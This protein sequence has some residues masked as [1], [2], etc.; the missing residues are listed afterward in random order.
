MKQSNNGNSFISNFFNLGVI[1][2]VLTI[3]KMFFM[4]YFSFPLSRTTKQLAILLLLFTN[5]FVFG[6]KNIYKAQVVTMYYDNINNHDDG[7]LLDPQITMPNQI[8]INPKSYVRLKIDNE[9]GPFVWVKASI[10]VTMIPYLADGTPNTENAIT[11]TLTAEY[12]PY[13]N[14]ANFSD[15]SVYELSNSY[16]VNVKIEGVEFTNLTTGFASNEVTQNVSIELGFESERYYSITNQLPVITANIESD[17]DGMPLALNFNWSNLTGALQYELQ[18]TWVDNYE[19]DGSIK[20]PELIN[21][22]SRDFELNNTKIRTNATTYQIPL[23]YSRGYIIFRV[24]GV[25]RFVDDANTVD[26]EYFG[27]WSSGPENKTTVATWQNSH[28]RFSGHEDKKNW[29]FQ[30][31]YAEQGKKKEVVSYFDGS[32]R[33]RQTVTK[34]NTDKNNIVVGE[35][36]YDTQGRAAVEVLPAPIKKNYIRYFKELNRNIDNTLYSHLDFDWDITSEQTC[37]IPAGIMSSESG[38]SKYYSNN[39]DFTDNPFRNNIPDAL[40]YPFSQIEYTPDN[41]GRIARKGGVGL[42]HQ[43]GTNHE[44]KY[45]YSVPHQEELNR[46]FG[47][48]VG[49]VSHYK[50][51]IVVDPNG[52]VSVSYIDPQGRTIATALAGDSPNNMIPLKDSKVDFSDFTIDL[53]N[54]ANTND[55]DTDLDNNEL[56][57]S[58]NFLNHN[59]ILTLSKQIGVAGNNINHSFKYAFRN[60]QVFIPQKCPEI[61]SFVYNLQISLKDQCN[62]NLLSP[63][64]SIQLGNY[65]IGGSSTIDYSHDFSPSNLLLNTGNYSLVK[66]LK[67][68]ENTLND[69]ADHYVRMLTDKKFGGSCYINPN[70]FSPQLNI[71]C[72]TTCQE[73]EESIGTKCQYVLKQIKNI[74]NVPQTNT[75]LFTQNG[76]NCSIIV[77][78]LNTNEDESINFGQPISQEEVNNQV[79]KIISDWNLLRNTCDKICGTA[80]ASSC[81]INAMSL[82]NDVS[83]G[84]QYGMM[85]G[86]IT[87]NSENPVNNG[88]PANLNSN[89]LSVFN[90]NN[91]I[92]YNGQ[93]N[94]AVTTNNHFD[95]RHPMPMYANEDGSL[96]KIEVEFT[97]VTSDNPSGYTPQVV[98]GTTIQEGGFVYPQDLSSVDDFIGKWK[99]TWAKSL[100]KYHPEYCYL[101]YSNNVCQLTKPT[102]VR[103]FVVNNSGQTLQTGSVT[104]PL[105]SDEYDGYLNYLDTYEKARQAGL[106]DLSSPMLTNPVIYSNDPYF[107]SIN[108]ETASFLGWRQNIMLEAL[109][110]QYETNLLNQN[111][112]A[113]DPTNFAKMYQ[114]A[115]IMARCNAIQVCNYNDVSL[116]NLSFTSLPPATQEIIKNRIWNTYKNLYISLKQKIKHVFINMYAKSNGCYNGCIGT[117]GS[118]NITNVISNYT[119]YNSVNTFQQINTYIAANNPTSSSTI[120]LCSLPQS[121]AYNSKIKKFIPI[122]YGYDSGDLSGSINQLL[123]LSN[124]QY[125]LQ[126]GNCPLVND[127]NL[128]LN[129]LFEDVNL[130]ASSPLVGWN[131]IGQGLTANLFH[132]LTGTTIPTTSAP[133]MV[134]S[135]SANGYN[136]NFTFSPTTPGYTGTAS[137]LLLTLPSTS[138]LN[139]NDYSINNNSNNNWHIIG[140][141]QL[142]YDLL[143]SNLAANPPVYAFKIIARIQ[144]GTGAGTFRDVILTGT[145]IAKIGACH[146][147]GQPGTGQVITPTITD[148]D[149]KKILFENAFKELYNHLYQTNHLYDSAYNLASDIVYQGSFLRTMFGSTPSDNVIWKST[150]DTSNSNYLF[151]IFKNGTSMLAIQFHT[152]NFFANGITPQ[153]LD[154]LSVDNYIYSLLGSTSEHG[155][156]VTGIF[157]TNNGVVTSGGSL[158]NC[159]GNNCTEKN[160]I[161]LLCCSPCGEW[162]FNGN[163]IGDACEGNNGNCGTVDTDGDGDF[164]NCDNCPLKVNPDQADADGDGIGDAC[165]TPIYQNVTACPGNPQLESIYENRLKDFLNYFVNPSNHTVSSTGNFI[166]SGVPTSSIPTLVNFV[167]QAQLQ[168]LFQN[169]RNS[170]HNLDP[171]YNEP[172]ILDGFKIYG[173]FPT[174]LDFYNFSNP[175]IPN[176]SNILIFFNFN[177]TSQINFFDIIDQNHAILNYTNLEGVSKNVTVDFGNYTTYKVQNNTAFGSFFCPFITQTNYIYPTPGVSKNSQSFI[178]T[179]VDSNGT[180][181]FKNNAGTV[182]DTGAGAGTG[183]ITYTASTAR[184]SATNITFTGTN[185]FSAGE[186]LTIESAKTTAGGKVLLSLRFSLT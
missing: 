186:L 74:Y 101:E 136:L 92:I 147:E 63:Y 67:V 121:L 130:A 182:M 139:W 11:Q 145:T 174:V 167:Q 164:D 87:N 33:N 89:L 168:Q 24:R 66:E 107:Q 114:A 99:P 104:R 155:N 142:Y 56:S 106:F 12:N 131:Q 13:G 95:W 79:T 171:T 19:E 132:E 75:T 78:N 151:E 69:Y 103:Q 170:F 31:S 176:S 146:L 62:T 150:N 175:G 8:S 85:P 163:G 88:S 59:D 124:Y 185:T 140:F 91:Q 127:L 177:N 46:L 27:P 25:G 44:M 184:D 73:C 156:Y 65:D 181:T 144:Q 64:D 68:D 179:T 110:S 38:T 165:D 125:Y 159:Q 98:V 134:V 43:L 158:A 152:Y 148:C 70:D 160:P 30:A 9:I 86:M 120:P 41:T 2:V 173:Q 135:V 7:Y 105:N 23:I 112:L 161:Y 72:E 26:K 153:D 97:G 118:G 15:L 3:K 35:V 137:Q 47:Y 129:G 143:T 57:S 20:L 34:V 42:S 55:A 71:D 17:D 32:L 115:L 111:G 138:G 28:I 166:I 16:G 81:S 6:Q 14:A 60:N 18:W 172:V 77:N 54:K 36:I 178:E 4:N 122:D 22:S 157:N 5:A 53:L 102:V 51:N 126:T 52:Q 40:N 84:G 76:S 10:K 39:N 116:T 48:Q 113:T 82:E 162:D 133:T 180:I 169:L 141:N 50:K 49:Y 108:G 58:Y 149:D 29:Q 183:I 119:S 96:S 128:F 37:G 117:G 1:S 94:N 83:P 93:V 109:N 100:I 80:F 90:E 45:F 123:S 154:S 61:Y 21:F